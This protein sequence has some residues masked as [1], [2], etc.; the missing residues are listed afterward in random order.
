LEYVILDETSF[1]KL[2]RSIFIKYKGRKIVI[3]NLPYLVG[4]E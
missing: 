3:K 2:E 4:L 1:P